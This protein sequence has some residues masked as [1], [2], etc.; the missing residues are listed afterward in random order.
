MSGIVITYITTLILSIIPSKIRFLFFTFVILILGIFFIL[1]IFSITTYNTRYNRYFSAIILQ[2]NMNEATEFLNVYLSLKT[3]IYIISSISIILITVTTI[4][5]HIHLSQKASLICF[6]IFLL[7][8][9]LTT[10]NNAVYKESI[11]NKLMGFGI[12]DIPDLDN[13][14]T[15]PSLEI[16]NTLPQNVVLILGESFNKYHSSLYGYPKKTN[17]LLEKLKNEQH[18]YI[19]PNITSP[20]VGTNAAFRTI[21]NT[22]RPEYGEDKPWYTYTSLPEILHICGYHTYWISNQDEKGLH[23]VTATKYAEICS[24]KYFTQKKYMKRNNNQFDENILPLIQPTINYDKLNFYFLHLM[25]SHQAYEERYPKTFNYFTT[26]DYTDSIENQR[27][28]LAHYDNTILYNDF[29][30]NEII[31]LFK[32]NETIIIYTSDHGEDLFQSNP[33]FAGHGIINN[34]KSEKII[35]EIPFIIYT[36]PLFIQHYPQAIKSIENN[37]NKEFRTDDLI[38]TIMDIIGV[39]FK[40][41]NDVTK[42]SLFNGIKYN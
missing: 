22:Y 27:A 5:K 14:Y 38:Y 19:F 16:S 20:A 25:G 29:I 8:S 12:T 31:K 36:S 30:I 13:F 3:I 41:N 34:E 33:N 32:N 6:G 21:L 40:N 7:S 1:D 11:I 37:L 2:T 10:R 9:I 35:K 24:E 39:S 4:K 26:R 18:L 28:S 23:D 17:P 42:Y 15:N